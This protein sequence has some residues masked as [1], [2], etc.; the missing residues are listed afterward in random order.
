M[1]FRGHAEKMRIV[2]SPRRELNIQGS[3]G[4]KLHHFGYPFSRHF[5]GT[6]KGLVF[7]AL[8]G[9]HWRKWEPKGAPRVPQG[10]PNGAQNE[11]KPIKNEGLGEA[12]LPNGSPGVPRS[13]LE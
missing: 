11:A 4:S 12:L 9:P 3:R 2:L 6:L 10:L 8:N 7:L 1:T 13:H 5:L